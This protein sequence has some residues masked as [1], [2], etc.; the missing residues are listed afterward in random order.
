MK[1]DWIAEDWFVFALAAAFIAL[2][3]FGLGVTASRHGCADSLI[4]CIEEGVYR[5]QTLLAALFAFLGA[6]LGARAL[7]R[8]IKQSDDQHKASLRLHFR[9]EL[10]AL[11]GML[12][13][14][15]T[16]DND[17]HMIQQGHDA[18]P[19]PDMNLHQRIN[20]HAV[21]YVSRTYN[22]LLLAIDRYNE[23]YKQMFDFSHQPDETPERLEKL[24]AI[25]EMR[26]IVMGY[27]SYRREE[28]LNSH[29]E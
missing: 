24:A 27:I 6:T 1:H 20:M 5:Y 12:G 10:D 13:D 11:E 25:R 14:L 22:E 15:N 8:Q 19:V 3:F 16:M 2:L 28:L 23:D 17:W 4:S 26:R 7:W 18:I 29:D 21:W 9:Q